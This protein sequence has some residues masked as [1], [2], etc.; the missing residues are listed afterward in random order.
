MSRQDMNGVRTPQNLEQKYDFSLLKK[1]AKNFELQKNGINKLENEL[2]DFTNQVTKDITDLKGQVDGK[3]ATWFS[4]G[5]PEL[6]NYPAS[7][8]INYESKIEHLADIY[9]DKET[10]Y[11][12]RFIQQNT[13][14]FEWIL[15]NDTALT[16]ALA[17]ANK[18]KDT[19]D[20]KRQIFIDVPSPPYDCGDI[21]IK[22]KEIYR[23][24]TAKN[25]NESFE[26]NDWIIAT[27]YTDDTRANQVGENLTILSG[28]VT[29]IRK[30][31]NELNNTMKK[32]TELVDDQSQKISSLETKSSETSQTVDSIS[33]TVSAI[34]SNLDNNYTSSEELNQKLAEQTNTVTNEMLT[35]FEQSKDGFTFD[36]L[37]KINK[38]GI[39]SLINTMVNISEEGISI[40]KNDEDIISKLNN[41]GVY[42]SDGK[43]KEDDSNL[44]MKADRSGAL[45]KSSNTLG[46]IKEQGIIQKEK[47]VDDDFGI[48]QAWY[49]IGDGS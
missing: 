28:T 9:Y 31:V 23:C 5:K 24:Q 42:V 10:G 17:L 35:K 48:C 29:E 13:D 49:W 4:S 16:Q 40:A 26:E 12:Y 27:K 1:F 15:I 33:S 11:A 2:F 34:S 38:E 45:F 14:T 19:A 22:D 47:L 20:K 43:L 3:I 32:T 41:E 37:E 25:E 39:S 6:T 30:N 46:T 21:W 8:W 7:D 18:A 44:L 36:I